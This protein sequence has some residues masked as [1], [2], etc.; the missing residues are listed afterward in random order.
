[1]VTCSSCA[2]ENPAAAR[3][4]FSCGRAIGGEELE[5]REERRVVTVLF[6]DMVA[7][8]SR[9]ERL[10]PEDLGAILRS[11]H[12]RVRL[13]IESFGGVTEKFIGDAVVGIFGAPTAYGDDPERAV[14]AALAVRTAIAELNRGDEALDLHVRIGVNTGDALVT[15]GARPELG[16]G[17]VTGDVV[18]MAARLQQNAPADGILAGLETY[19]CTRDAVTYGDVISITAKGKSTPLQARPALD[20]P[21]RSEPAPRRPI[22]GRERE[23]QHLRQIWAQAEE[24]A[25]PHLVTVL[26]PPGVGKTRLSAEFSVAVRDAGGRVVRGRSLP[27]RESSAYGAFAAQVKQL[28]GIFESDPLEVGRAKLRRTVDG[29]GAVD[30]D[31]VT[32]HLGIL[33]GLEPEQTVADRETLFFSVRCF[34]EAVAEDRPTMLVFEDLHWA[35][36]SLLDLVELLGAQLRGSPVVL[37]V[38]AR[39]ELLD[40]RPGWGGGLPAYTALSLQPLAEDESRKLADELLGGSGTDSL[41]ALAAHVST[42]AEGNPL[43]IEQLA[44]VALERA[45]NALLNETLPTTIRGIVTARLDSLPPEERSVLLD[46]AVVGKVF[47]RG[48][49]GAVTD[50]AGQLGDVLGALERRDLIRRDRESAIEG[51]PQYAFKHVLIRDAAYD[52]LTRPQ[53]RERHRRVAQF[54]EHETSAGGET[55]AP[56]ARHWREAG[57]AER[58]VEHFVRAAEQAGRGW[59][60]QH[61]VELYKE[62][63]DL[64]PEESARHAEIRRQFAIAY[65]A[66]WH[67]QDVRGQRRSPA[68]PD[69]G[70]TSG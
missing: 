63:L 50:D 25:T 22:V 55:T 43:F 41:S 32:S 36:P 48:A 1:M 34:I 60:K 12:D 24:T 69:P 23:M 66:S 42:T 16:E 14:R 2:Q 70:Q 8:T 49:L 11:Y 38:L 53:R 4:C 26:A 9:A 6:V 33:I 5:P 37:L 40:A 31:A 52:M 64:I 29:L 51:D 35:D 19:A 30:A 28:A 7:F 57:D 44:A 21:S 61:A 67:V 20:S 54:L 56:L 15:I 45:E 17:M 58:A 68:G 65:Q 39:P 27:Y 47:W 59:A 13:E 3:F 46:A 18:N 10:D 62:A